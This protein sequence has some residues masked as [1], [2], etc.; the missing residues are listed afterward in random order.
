MA[1]TTYHP[2]KDIESSDCGNDWCPG[3]NGDTLP[4]FACFARGCESNGAVEE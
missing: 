3:P 2:E 1:T 4:C